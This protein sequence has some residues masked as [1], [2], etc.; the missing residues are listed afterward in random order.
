MNA[1][2][3]QLIILAAIQLLIVAATMLVIVGISI[4]W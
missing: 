2:V 3:F 1:E 4:T